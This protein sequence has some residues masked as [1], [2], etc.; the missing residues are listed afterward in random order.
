MKAKI[1]IALLLINTVSATKLKVALSADLKSWI[2]ISEQQEIEEENVLE[3]TMENSLV[4]EAEIEDKTEQ[5]QAA[6]TAAEEKE[7]VEEKEDIE[8]TEYL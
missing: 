1:V 5:E 3:Q 8:G 7:N 2:Q 6:A 4:N